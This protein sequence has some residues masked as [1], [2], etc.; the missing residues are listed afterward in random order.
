MEY[1]FYEDRLEQETSKT[2]LTVMYKDFDVVYIM[3]NSMIIIF[4]KKVIVMD[5][6]SFVD[7][8]DTN[9]IEFLKEKSIKVIESKA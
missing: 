8:S 3:K 2:E 9:V 5:R 1:R 4:N 6:N 7:V